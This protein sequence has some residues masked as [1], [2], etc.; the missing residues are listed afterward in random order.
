MYKNEIL[1]FFPFLQFDRH[2]ILNTFMCQQS[3][4]NKHKYHGQVIFNMLFLN[5]L[6]YQDFKLII[7]TMDLLVKLSLDSCH[8]ELTSI[9][10]F[11]SVADLVKG[12][13]L[14]TTGLI[15]NLL[16]L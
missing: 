8:E 3:F 2:N 15:V 16:Y 11:T 13:Y 10:Q 12:V 1:I 7:S 5:Q 9:L 6:L 4:K 14:A